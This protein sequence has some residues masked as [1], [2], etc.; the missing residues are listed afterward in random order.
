MPL[1]HLHTFLALSVVLLFLFFFLDTRARLQLLLLA[2]AAVVPAT[3]FTWLITDHFHAG[4][5]LT[6]NPGWVQNNGDFARPLAAF[7]QQPA[8]VT[9]P[10]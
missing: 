6:W 5:I 9:A 4:S 1:F 8:T 7:T 2:G 10:P 3:L